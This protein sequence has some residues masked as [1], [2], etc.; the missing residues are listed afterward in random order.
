MD[1]IIFTGITQPQTAVSYAQNAEGYRFDFIFND[2]WYR[3]E[4][5]FMVDNMDTTDLNDNL[6]KWYCVITRMF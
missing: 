4:M 6:R 1:L 2:K 3:V 5:S